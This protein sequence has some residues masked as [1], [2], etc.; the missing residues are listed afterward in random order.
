LAIFTH[1]FLRLAGAAAWI[2]MALAFQRMLA[3]YHRSRLWGFA[4]PAIAA[5]Y[6]GCTLLSGW[7]HVRGRGGIWKGRIQAAAGR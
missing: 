2:L 7:E 1:G 6:A 3:F 4:L 5:F